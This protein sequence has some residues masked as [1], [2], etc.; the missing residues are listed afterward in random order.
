[1][2]KKIKKINK[3]RTKFLLILI[4]ILL[5]AILNLLIQIN[6]KQKKI[7]TSRAQTPPVCNP[8]NVSMSANP[9][10]ARVGENITFRVS[11]TE[12]DTFIE[13]IWTPSDGVNCQGNFWGEK[14]CQA[15]RDGQFVWWHKWKKCIGSFENCSDFCTKAYLFSI[16]PASTNPTPT[17]IATPTPTP[18]PIPTPTPTAT[19]TPTP[20]PVNM[21]I[22]LRLKFQGISKKPADNLN[23]LTVKITFKNEAKSINEEVRKDFRA[24]DQLIWLSDPIEVNL[25][26]DNHYVI[27]IKGPKHLQKKICHAQPEEGSAGE[28]LCRNSYIELKSG[29]NNL[30]FSKITLLA[31]DLPEQ[32]NILNSYDLSLV[33]NNLGKN[34]NESLNKADINLDGVVDTQDFS[35]LLSSMAIKP[36][37]F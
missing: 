3:N 9:N 27:L 20:G 15:L 26:A 25:P 30:D 8:N 19:L 7:L 29:D 4:F 23:R 35:L 13:D 18:T 17:P 16:L 36:D 10:P 32:D 1:M 31:G 22:N 34:D 33:R 5:F 28:Y 14:T 6:N 21:K 11:G 24:N 37:E 2:S 12:G